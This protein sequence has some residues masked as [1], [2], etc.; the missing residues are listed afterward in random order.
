MALPFEDLVRTAISPSTSE[1]SNPHQN[2]LNAKSAADVLSPLLFHCMGLVSLHRIIQT[3][4]QLNT[5][6][7]REELLTAHIQPL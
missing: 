6:H 1:F 7:G 3:E 2:H 4:A 5:V